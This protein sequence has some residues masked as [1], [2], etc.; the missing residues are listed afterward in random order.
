MKK[1][2]VDLHCHPTLK[3]YGKSFMRRYVTGQNNPNTAEQN[4]IWHQQRPKLFRRVA[5]V[6][7][8]LTKWRQSDM[9]TLIQ[10][11]NRVIVASLYPL[12]KGMV[13]HD[14]ADDVK[15]TGRL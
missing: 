12:E 11:N 5:N 1:P 15:F 8:S 7:L 4:S 3:P 14:D 10:G 9:Y 13:K 6:L 2:I